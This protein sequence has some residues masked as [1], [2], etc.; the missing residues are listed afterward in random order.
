MRIIN[1]HLG[2]GV[3][4][5]TFDPSVNGKMPVAAWIPSRDDSGNETTLLT[6]LAGANDG[7]LIDMDPDTDWVADTDFGGVRKI[8]FDGVNDYV[9]VPHTAGLNGDTRIAVSAWIKTGSN[10]TSEQH[11]LAKSRISPIA[12]GYRLYIQDG[13]F[14]FYISGDGGSANRAFRASTAIS[15]NTWYHVLGEYI[16]STSLDIYI[17]SALANGTLT[18]SIPA[19]CFATDQALAI[20]CQYNGTTTTREHADVAFDDIRV[21]KTPLESSDRIALATSRGIDAS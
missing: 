16:A 11:V 21:F 8:D 5:G 18:G 13:A 6:D 10:V 4:P 9:A 19:S 7:T 20:G 14:R 12:I 1:S 17:N 15:S 3:A 2:G